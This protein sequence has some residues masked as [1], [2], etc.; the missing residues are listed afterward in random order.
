MNLSPALLAATANG[1]YTF[2]WQA[3]LEDGSVVSQFEDSL[4]Q[5]ILTAPELPANL[6]EQRV[7]VER[8]DVRKVKEFFLLPTGAARACNS[9]LSP[10]RLVVNLDAGEKFISYWL[11]DSS[12]TTGQTLSRHVVG[13]SKPVNGSAAKFFVIINPTGSQTI[14]TDD[15][16]SYD[17]E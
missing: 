2:V 12:P 9:C 8:L 15:N 13:L 1:R 10:I 16:Q 4:L 11:T 3:L 7:S 14:A 17:G 5:Q 6:E